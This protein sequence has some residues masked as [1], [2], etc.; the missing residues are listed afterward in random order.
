MTPTTLNILLLGGTSEAKQ[1]ARQL[2][3]AKLPHYDKLCLPYSLVRLLRQPVLPCRIICGV[4][5]HYGG[6]TDYLIHQK[7]DLLVD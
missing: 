3:A 4:F 1:L 7:I 6:L 2:Y 5:I